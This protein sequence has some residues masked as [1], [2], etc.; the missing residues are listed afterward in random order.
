M[1]S[2]L[3]SLQN[4]S[5]VATIANTNP[6]VA[7]RFVGANV[8]AQAVS[9]ESLAQGMVDAEEADYDLAA[10]IGAYLDIGQAAP[11]TVFTQVFGTTDGIVY[12]GDPVYACVGGDLLE[13]VL[14]EAGDA[15]L[16]FL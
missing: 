13:D 3:I 10:D 7:Y 11:Q 15:L 5:W 2:L 12:S 1:P 14:A 16:M 9:V 6:P 8:D 4:G